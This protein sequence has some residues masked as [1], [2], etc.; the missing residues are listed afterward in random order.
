MHKKNLP[1]LTSLRTFDV[2][3]SHG[4]FKLAAEE[5]K[6]T[7]TAVSHQ[8]RQLEDALGIKVLQRSSHKV[9]LTTAGKRLK[10]ATTSAFELLWNTVSSIHNTHEKN[11]ISLTATAN[12]VS[13]WLMPRLKKLQLA[14]PSVN[15]E[16]QASDHTID[17]CKHEID[18]AIRYAMKVDDL[19]SWNFLYSDE[20][21]LVSSPVLPVMSID[22]LKDLPLIHIDGRLVPS[23]TPDWQAW[24]K[25]WGP[26]DLSID[27]GI[28]FSEETHAIQAAIA[29]QGV[30]IVSHLMAKNALQQG[31]LYEPFKFRLGGGTFYFVTTKEKSNR[32]D[33]KQIFNWFKEN[34]DID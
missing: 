12:F 17:L 4:S 18:I 8:I 24:Q 14:Y 25:K 2:V 22:S 23:V 5:L 7:P 13:N 20:F 27:T 32:S 16:L 21:I 1:T 9:R 28:R 30:A 29:G 19:L 6:V 3:A 31:L 33:I 15:L 11:R 26:D 34:L 10:E